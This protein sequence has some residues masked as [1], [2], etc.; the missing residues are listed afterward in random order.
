MILEEP[1]FC[2]SN[3]KYFFLLFL[4]L[5]LNLALYNFHCSLEYVNLPLLFN[6]LSPLTGAFFFSLQ[7]ISPW[8]FLFKYSTSVLVSP[9]AFYQKI[10][11]IY[12]NFCGFFFS[13]IIVS[14]THPRPAVLM[15]FV[16]NDVH[17]D[18]YITYNSYGTLLA[19]LGNILAV[20]EMNNI[21]FCH[22]I[23]M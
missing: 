6:V 20:L 17:I 23:Y 2:L 15:I 19:Y 8:Y 18:S 16:G 21:K 7:A 11:K 12:V 5:Y 3:C 1:V 13:I 4:T 22:L 14:K 10:L 9:S